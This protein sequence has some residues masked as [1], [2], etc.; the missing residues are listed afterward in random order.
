M[1]ETSPPYHTQRMRLLDLPAEVLDAVY[2]R[3]CVKARARLRTTAKKIEKYIYIYCNTFKTHTCI[4]R[5][6][7]HRLSIYNGAQTASL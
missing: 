2:D 6:R 3:A 7:S 4:Y 5:R 1:H